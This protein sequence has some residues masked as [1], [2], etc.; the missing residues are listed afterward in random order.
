M[1]PAHDKRWR[2]CTW[3]EW[4]YMAVV[5]VTGIGAMA[6]AL[7]MIDSFRIPHNIEESSSLPISG[8]R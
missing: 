4:L 7:V 1:W 5:W 8:H 6:L 3:R 2:D